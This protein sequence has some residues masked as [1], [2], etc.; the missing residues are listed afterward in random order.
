MRFRAVGGPRYVS[1][2]TISGMARGITWF[3]FMCHW[4]NSCVR[5]E[6]PAFHG[7]GIPAIWQSE[8]VFS[9]HGRDIDAR[10]AQK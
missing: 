2:L 5:A 7:R 3:N 10:E 8:A 6:G 9:V 4:R 1:F